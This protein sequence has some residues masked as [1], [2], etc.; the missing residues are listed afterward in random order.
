M[1]SVTQ[2]IKIISDGII[3][4]IIKETEEI[5]HEH[6]SVHVACGRILSKYIYS[7]CNVPSFR[8]SAKCGYAIKAND[9]ENIKKILN[10]EVS[11]NK[12][13]TYIIN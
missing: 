6:V 9:G 1:I 8:T 3:K 11:D 2:A 12:Y 5:E 4:G 13:S 10:A 7:E